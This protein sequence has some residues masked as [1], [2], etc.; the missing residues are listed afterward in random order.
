M[1]QLKVIN[2]IEH[3]DRTRVGAQAQAARRLV[4][5]KRTDLRGLEGQIGVRRDEYAALRHARPILHARPPEFDEAHLVKLPVALKPHG[6]M[7]TD[8]DDL[9]GRHFRQSQR[10]HGSRFAVAFAALIGGRGWQTSAVQLGAEVEGEEGGCVGLA[11]TEEVG[12]TDVGR[13]GQGNAMGRDR[14]AEFDGWNVV[15]PGPFRRAGN[16]VRPDLNRVRCSMCKNKVVRVELDAH[17]EGH[18]T[19]NEWVIL[20]NDVFHEA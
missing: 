8:G 10:A 2:I 9:G 3:K 4:E 5:L 15:R 16:L 7:G 18:L 11:R 20:G 17:A 13:V 12:D 19:N 6:T 1:R 14:V